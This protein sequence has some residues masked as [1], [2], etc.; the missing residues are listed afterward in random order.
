MGVVKSGER[1][2]FAAKVATPPPPFNQIP[3]LISMKR[4]CELIK[5]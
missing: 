2:Y 5:L 3:A 1:N 4:E